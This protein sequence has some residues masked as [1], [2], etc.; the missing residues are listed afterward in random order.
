MLNELK[1]LRQYGWWLLLF[2]TLAVITYTLA[3]LQTPAIAS[4][5]L[6]NIQIMVNK[7]LHPELYPRDYVFSDDQ[8]FRFYIPWYRSLVAYLRQLGGSFERGL[9]FLVP[10]LMATYVVGMT[11]LLKR[12]SGWFAVG[13][14]LALVS[15]TYRSTMGSEMWGVAVSNEMVARTIFTAL[16]PWLLW[17]MLHWLAHPTIPLSLGLGLAVGLTANVHPTSGLFM[18]GFCGGLFGLTHWRTKAGWL[19]MG[20][21]AIVTLLG[22]LPI[23]G[24]VVGNTGAAVANTASFETFSQIVI[25]RIKIPFRPHDFEFDLLDVTIARPVLD[26]LVWIYVALSLGLLGLYLGRYLWL[27]ERSRYVWLGGG[28]LVWAYAWLTALFNE[29]FFFMVVGGYI[30]YRFYRPTF[31]ALDWWSLGF[32]ALTVLYS[33]VGYYLLA[34]VWQRFEVWSLTT[35]LIEQSRAARYVYVPLFML[36]GRAAAAW[37]P[38]FQYRLNLNSPVPVAVA[39]GLLLAMGGGLSKHLFETV[40]GV[41][42]SLLGAVGFVALIALGLSYG[43]KRLRYGQQVGFILLGLALIYFTPLGVYFADYSPLP[44]AVYGGD[45]EP[46]DDEHLESILA[47]SDWV[48][49]ET[50]LQA[51]FFPCGLNDKLHMRFRAE[52]ER[53]ITH[54]WKDLGLATYNRA[55]LVDFYNRYQHL[56]NSCNSPE[57]L[58]A[59]ANEVGADYVIGFNGWPNG[60]QVCFSHKKYAVYAVGHAC[61]R[62]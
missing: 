47:I 52:G 61:E 24:S 44:V 20:L 46:D 23:A 38:E 43:A 19:N 22:A 5:D 8:F 7:D 58:V 57:T 53:S 32:L 35:L 59:A 51:L 42:I 54:S 2:T 62:R 11:L 1:Q 26:Y 12:V 4:G 29:P 17:L 41:L 21:F 30:I 37:I 40:P 16:A 36:T 15:T 56:S 18:A 33:F 3:S 25:E 14:G 34:W 49:N 10:P 55:A 48:K 45:Y 6:D 60:M 31:E 13:L 39:S 27:R 50:S 9:I 28:L